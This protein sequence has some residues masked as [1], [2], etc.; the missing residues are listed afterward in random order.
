MGM[1]IGPL[2]FALTVL[3]TLVVGATATVSQGLQ[4]ESLKKREL[5]WTPVRGKARDLAIS[6][7]GEVF[8][9]GIDETVWHWERAEAR[10]RKTS[11]KLVR[12]TVAKDERPWGVA[13]D[14][15]IYRRN[16]LWWDTMPGSA[17]DIA[18]GVNGSTY[19]IGLDG[20]ISLWET[21]GKRWK[22][23]IGRKGARIAVAPKGQP[24]VVGEKGAIAYFDG[25]IWIDVP[26][27][28]ADIAID[29]EGTVV[30]ALPDG[31]LAQ[32][33]DK[34]RTWSP[35]A[36][37]AGARSLAVGPGTF[38]WYVTE[39]GSVFA[40]SLF[41]VTEKK[42]TPTAAAPGSVID[43]A[44]ITEEGPYTF[45]KIPGN[46][47]RLAIGADGSVFALG[48]DGA[49]LRWSNARN[50]FETFPG[51]VVRIA[52]A[53]DGQP[54]GLNS[55][56]EIFR[57]DGSD[58]KNIKGEGKEIAIGADGTVIVSDADEILYRFNGANN[59]VRVSGRGEKL[60]VT[61]AGVPWTIRKN[62][63][64]YRCD[65]DPCARIKRSGRDIAIGPDG[66]VFMMTTQ[67]TLYRYDTAA[68]D[69]V[70]VS[71]GRLVSAIAV[72]PRGLPWFVDSKNEVYA[73]ALF[74]RDESRDNLIARATTRPTVV[75]S[76]F[77]PSTSASTS[78]FAFKKNIAF[79]EITVD[80]GSSQFG[81][82]SR[83]IGI[84]IDGTVYIVGNYG[85]QLKVYNAKSKT[86]SDV[87]F[88]L[89]ETA[90]EI[91]ADADG[92][93][94]FASSES[95]TVFHQKKKGGSLYKSYVLSG[96]SNTRDIAVGGDGTVFAINGNRHLYKYNSTKDKFEIFDNDKFIAV[97]VTPAGVPWVVDFDWNVREYI[98]KKFEK[99]GNITKQAGDI[100]IGASGATYITDFN[101]NKIEKWNAA[102]QSY[103]ILT[104]K[105]GTDVAVQPD[106]SPWY[107]NNGSTDNAFKAK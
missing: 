7:V 40:S 24:W 54:W 80:N 107:L 20:T 35:L 52:I 28:A 38:P 36:G 15:K 90:A 89:P 84:G 93:I 49:M 55:K 13:A 77:A 67:N 50:K 47:Q 53:P 91:A 100:A 72:G 27:V 30:I 1:R 6:P 41:P 51:T 23:I 98:G 76:I 33:D 43:P 82:G 19:M 70:R 32:W 58:W 85:D 78:V 106:G 44:S 10:W 101:N 74:E 17:Q 12:I 29:P 57:H 34:V 94:W 62:G 65:V 102:N 45:T 86:I 8:A 39:D 14:G 4:F 11:G 46:A 9:A 71:T 73:A 37:A 56:R 88:S 105:T 48:P 63:R 66:S 92:R 22:T 97:A 21:F 16:G 96:D 59:F 68:E 75:T 26:G 99:P 79:E 25:E 95:D 104:G 83:A 69:W 60:A 18:A 64:I 5:T 3:A 2:A 103:D 81:N 87:A 61:P 31:G 42:T